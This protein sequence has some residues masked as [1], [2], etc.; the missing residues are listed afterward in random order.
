[1]EVLMAT[2]AGEE[3]CKQLVSEGWVSYRSSQQGQVEA[4]RGLTWYTRGL[5]Y[6]EGW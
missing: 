4:L 1:M 5:R 6:T 3:A 2:Q